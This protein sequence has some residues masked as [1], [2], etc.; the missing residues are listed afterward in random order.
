M[1]NQTIR[2]RVFRYDPE[3][4]R[5]AWY[6]EYSLSAGRPVTIL[7]LL[8]EIQGSQDSSLSFRRSCGF[9]KCGACAVRVNNRPVLACQEVVETGELLI[10]PL[11]HRRVIK[12][13]VVEWEQ[14]GP[15]SCRALEPL[16]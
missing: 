10:E 1:N 16:L 14:P 5:G 11:Q 2:V 8:L 4:K 12:D 3:E 15:K 7:E 9:G 13:L 6:R